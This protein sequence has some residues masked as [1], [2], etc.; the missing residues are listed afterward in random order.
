MKIAK[1]L[2]LLAV[3]MTGMAGSAL[4]DGV[5]QY[6]DADVLGTGS[7]GSD[8]TA[9]ATQ[10][11]LAP[12]ATTFAS[13]IT[14]HSFGFDP[15]GDF[16]GTDQIYVGSVQT[17]GHDGYS[18]YGGRINGPQILTLDY[19]GIVG[20]G[21]SVTG[22]TL[23][24]AADDFQNAVFGQAYSA[25]IN[26]TPYAPLTDALN[27][28]DQTGPVV[29]YFTIGIPTLL[30]TPDHTL[31]LSIDQGGDGGD[32]WAVDFLTVGVTTQVPAPAGAGLIALAGLAAAR[33][34]R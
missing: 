7:Y 34:R 32:G 15:A 28:F 13:L 3:G 19:S 17:G 23:G 1:V 25:S 30:L 2:A 33:R 22:L 18:G 31:I 14:G 5:G 29:Q 21:E 12:G 9:G 10:N 6:G 11:G 4:A 16:L 20:A 26:G 24:I 27:A 8:P